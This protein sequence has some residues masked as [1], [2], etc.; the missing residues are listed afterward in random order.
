[1]AHIT[2]KS[3]HAAAVAL[4][5]DARW[6]V[7]NAGDV[8]LVSDAE[9]TSTI[10]A[11]IRLRVSSVRAEVARRWAGAASS[12][13]IGGAAAGICGGL[14]LF[15]APMSQAAPQ[16]ALALAAIGAVAGGLGAGAVGAGLAAAEVLARS[17]RGLALTLCGA[18][19]G[20]LVALLAHALLQ[21][22]LEGL[23]GVHLAYTG[24]ALDGLILGA[25]AGAGYGLAT[26][27]P[28]GGGLAAPTGPARVKAVAFTGACCAVAAAALALEG[29]LMVGGLVHDIARTSRDAQLVLAPLGHL[30]GE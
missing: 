20:G 23:V 30:I 27:Q 3:G 9:A 8:P 7:P 10:A 17:R 16:S 25:A 11:L 2:S 21:A 14:V 6:N 12:G 24:G 18:A 22:I 15:L 13:A 1:M 29:R 28:P 26:R 5:R 4:M 19:A